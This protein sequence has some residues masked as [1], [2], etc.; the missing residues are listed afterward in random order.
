MEEEIFGPVIT[1]HVYEDA[2]FEEALDLCDTTSMY[3]LTG[4]I[5]AQDR[6]ML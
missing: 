3:A 4:A 2:K 1:I 5:W 6:Y